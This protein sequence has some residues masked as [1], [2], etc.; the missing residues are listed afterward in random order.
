MKET[1]YFYFR[2]KNENVSKYLICAMTKG[3]LCSNDSTIPHHKKLNN[4]KLKV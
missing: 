1:I 3:S 4:L 2:K